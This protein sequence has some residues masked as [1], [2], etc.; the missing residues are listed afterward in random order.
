MLALKEWAAQRC[1]LFLKEKSYS[2]TLW[3]TIKIL[4]PYRIRSKTPKEMSQLMKQNTKQLLKSE[5]NIIQAY[6]I[7][8]NSIFEAINRTKKNKDLK[9]NQFLISTICKLLSKNFTF[10]LH[11]KLLKF[12]LMKLCSRSKIDK[13][14]ILDTL[15]D[16]LYDDTLYFNTLEILKN[17]SKIVKQR[18]YEIDPIVLELI[19]DININEVSKSLQRKDENMPDIKKPINSQMSKKKFKQAKKLSKIQKEL[20]VSDA[21]ID[22]KTKAKN[23]QLVIEQAFFI[24]FSTIKFS[25]N[26]NLS[27]LSFKGLGLYSHLLN[28]DFFNDIMHCFKDF[29][30]APHK[31]EHHYQC[32]NSLFLMLIQFDSSII[33]DLDFYYKKLFTCLT[34]VD[35]NDEKNSDILDEIITNAFLK[36]ANFLKK[37]TFLMLLSVLLNHCF[38]KSYTAPIKLQPKIQSI[39]RMIDPN[40]IFLTNEKET[41]LENFFTCK[42]NQFVNIERTLWTMLL[43]PSFCK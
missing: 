15:K 27:M 5:Q 36:R 9:Y 28:L 4:P 26:L 12:I 34:L 24:F 23:C 41:E 8:I 32:L 13:T 14:E 40:D 25:S 39:Y 29:L 21:R 6:Q 17:I 11:S 18:K 3:K 43:Y 22:F 37:E 19:F 20:A 1:P 16:A 35:L 38:P 33:I 42:N 2:L 31:A 10:N 7:F 30:N